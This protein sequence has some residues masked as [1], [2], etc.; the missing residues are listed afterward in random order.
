MDD[1]VRREEIAHRRW[2]RLQLLIV[3]I[4]VCVTLLVVVSWT[5]YQDRKQDQQAAQFRAQ[6][7]A[8]CEQNQANA[9]SLRDFITRI[10]AATT[11]NDALTEA[12]KRERIRFYE[13]A[14]P[15]IPECPPK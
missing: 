4:A 1:Y 7:I 3:Y 11:D 6:V 10:Q 15:V 8:N 5:E 9:R 13:G 14:K 12:E 2:V